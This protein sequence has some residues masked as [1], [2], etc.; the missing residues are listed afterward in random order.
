M[1]NYV[2]LAFSLIFYAWGEPV[3][4]VLMLFASAGGYTKGPLHK[5]ERPL[6]KIVPAD[7]PAVKLLI[8]SRKPDNGACNELGKH[9]DIE[10]VI[11]AAL[12]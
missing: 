12:Q 7:M 8:Y 10:A 9:G 6:Y 2:L 3:Y 1:K 4:I 5:P 11:S